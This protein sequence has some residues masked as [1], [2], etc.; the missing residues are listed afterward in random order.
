MRFISKSKHYTHLGSMYVLNQRGI[1][2]N[3]LMTLHIKQILFCGIFHL[4]NIGFQNLYFEAF[5]FQIFGLG[6]FSL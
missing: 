6:I 1:I 2:C 3:L 5:Q 4:S